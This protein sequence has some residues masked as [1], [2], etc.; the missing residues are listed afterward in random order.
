[1]R[2]SPQLSDAFN[3]IWHSLQ[4]TIGLAVPQRLSIELLADFDTISVNVGI[5]DNASV[6]NQYLVVLATAMA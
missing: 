3:R 5:H 2:I 1:M 4:I 6:L